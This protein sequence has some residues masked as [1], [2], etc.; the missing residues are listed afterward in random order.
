MTLQLTEDK[1][2]RYI[3]ED[4]DNVD[5][6]PIAAVSF[7]TIPEYPRHSSELE[8]AYNHFVENTQ[9]NF[10]VFYSPEGSIVRLYYYNDEWKL[11]TNNKLDAYRASWGKSHYSSFGHAFNSLLSKQGLGENFNEFAEKHELDK[12]LTYVF[13]IEND[14]L[15]RIVCN[16]AP[17]GSLY[18]L[19]CFKHENE[20]TTYI[21][22]H[23]I[24]IPGLI[25]YPN[26]DV[27]LESIC[28]Y[29]NTIPMLEHQGVILVGD[30]GHA[31]RI[32]SDAYTFANTLR[33]NARDVPFRY[34]QLLYENYRNTN[35]SLLIMTFRQ[36][37]PLYAEKFDQYDKNIE[38][39]IQYI[40]SSY[41]KRCERKEFIHLHQSCYNFL[42]TFITVNG[43]CKF[44]SH[45]KFNERK[46]TENEY[47]LL[48]SIILSS[49]THQ[50]KHALLNMQ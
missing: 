41:M 11:S 46:I 38:S 49:P 24:N 44:R 9:G 25:N 30:N 45:E 4:N 34:K 16:R 27:S 15:N 35:V 21:N 2:Y 13:L 1:S 23:E 12:T 29:V 10:R 31:L 32:W 33:G 37:Y 36:L 47:N 6:A 8:N 22:D 43:W 42:N 7:G 19:G 50:I 18:F 5:K 17:M 20:K 26:T 3:F 40:Y 48:K 39:L 14:E 28:G